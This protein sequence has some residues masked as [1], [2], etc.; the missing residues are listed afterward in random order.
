LAEKTAAE[1]FD[2]LRAVGAR[3]H[4]LRRLLGDTMED[5]ALARGLPPRPAD[6]ELEGYEKEL[7]I[8]VPKREELAST[9]EI[10]SANEA[11]KK[12]AER[13]RQERD[14]S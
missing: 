10:I 2:E 14:E 3:I 6:D 13:R 1:L 9:A 12:E 4:E 5:A 7:A 11:L 8:L